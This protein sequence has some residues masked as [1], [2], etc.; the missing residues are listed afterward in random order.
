[1]TEP[2]YKNWMKK[3]LNCMEINYCCEIL[4]FSS[5]LYPHM[6]NNSICQCTNYLFDFEYLQ[7]II[8]ISIWRNIL[9]DILSGA[10]NTINFNSIDNE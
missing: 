7:E 2:K 1:V 3:W 5:D 8:S 4:K 10:E 6:K 9:A